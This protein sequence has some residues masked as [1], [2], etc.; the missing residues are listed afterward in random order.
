[1]T[2]NINMEIVINSDEPISQTKETLKN[3]HDENEYHKIIDKIRN[4]I[5]NREIV[6]NSKETLKNLHDENE[7]RH[8]IIEN[9]YIH[10]IIDKI[11]NEINKF[12]TNKFIYK[13]IIIIPKEKYENMFKDLD[14]HE[15]TE[16]Q[17]NIFKKSKDQKI[18]LKTRLCYYLSTKGRCLIG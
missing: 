2:H 17:K 7:Y 6:I 16:K 5:I 12:I 3:L 1:M 9:E 10:K 18:S 8:K 13:N 15:I 4:Q 11:T 14:L